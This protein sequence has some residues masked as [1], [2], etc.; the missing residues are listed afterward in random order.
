MIYLR[1][2]FLS[3]DQL[4]NTIFGGDP[5]LTISARIGFFADR[6]RQNPPAGG[7]QGPA[8]SR[9]KRCYWIFH[10]KIVNL[11]WKPVDGSSHCWDAYWDDRY[12]DYRSKNWWIFLI[13]MSI[14]VIILSL[15]IGVILYLLSLIIQ[16]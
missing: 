7:Q 10:E 13:P 12:E 15:V 5:D 11:A 2:L 3:F 9:C 6:C 16:F 1:N 4:L 8:L 14:L